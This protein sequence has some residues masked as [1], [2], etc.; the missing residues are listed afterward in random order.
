MSVVLRHRDLL[1]H[2][3]RLKVVTLLQHDKQTSSLQMNLTTTNL[4]L[5]TTCLLFY[6]ILFYFISIIFP[7]TNEILFSHVFAG[8]FVGS[9][10]GS[11]V[12]I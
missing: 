11:F 8:R 10:R 5:T 7:C 4:L 9:V 1:L 6:F 3:E 2:Y 12:S